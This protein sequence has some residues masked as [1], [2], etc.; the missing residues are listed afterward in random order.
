MRLLNV[1]TRELEEFQGNNTP[2]YAI[3]LYTWGPEEVTLHEM[4]AISRHL[5]YHHESA[6]HMVP[7][8]SNDPDAMK[9]MLLSTM[10][11]AFRR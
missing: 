6:T 9:F 2:Q 4:E 11:M 10:L 5:G 1:F 8:S 3:L 7:P